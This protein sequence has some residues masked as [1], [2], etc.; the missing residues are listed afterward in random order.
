MS[1]VCLVCPLCDARR[2][3]GWKQLLSTPRCATQKSVDVR[4]RC[5][6]FRCDIV[7]L[8]SECVGEGRMCRNIITLQQMRTSS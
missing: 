4:L 2:Y 7:M 1:G 6:V 5:G 8:M 3:V